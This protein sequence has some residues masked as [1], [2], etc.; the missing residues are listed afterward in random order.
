MRLK[1]H[2][3]NYTTDVRCCPER[4]GIPRFVARRERRETAGGVA[5]RWSTATPSGAKVIA[6]F[7]AAM[8]EPATDELCDV[9]DGKARR[10]VAGAERSGFLRHDPKHPE[11]GSPQAVEGRFMRAE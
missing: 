6:R 2:P 9:C 5:Q 4:G 10:Q 1:Y 7:V 3:C 8:P 11:S